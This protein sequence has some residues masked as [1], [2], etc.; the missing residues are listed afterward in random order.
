M[1]RTRLPMIL[2]SAS[3]FAA[4]PA[5]SPEGAD[6]RVVAADEVNS[7]ASVFLNDVSVLFPMPKGSEADLLLG[8]NS[9]GG[10]GEL[11]PQAAF[12]EIPPLVVGDGATRDDLRVVG[13]RIDPCFP[14]LG[15]EDPA[16]CLNQIRLVLQ[17]VLTNGPDTP[18]A[19]QD[20]SVHAFYTMSR[21]EFVAMVHEIVAAKHGATDSTRTPLGP[22]PL[23]VEQ[24]LSGPFA[25]KLKEIVLARAGKESLTRVTFMTREPAR[26]SMW[27]FGGFDVRDGVLTKLKIASLEDTT[28]QT[29]SMLLDN[30]TAIPAPQHE[31]DLSLLFRASEASNA[32]TEAL[33]KAYTAALKIQNPA[34]HSPDTIDCV[35]CHTATAAS[36]WSEKNK[37]FTS[38]G[39]PDAFTTSWNV[40][41]TNAP[42]VERRDNLHAFGYLGA[43]PSVNQR[44]ANESAL[45]ADYVNTKILGSR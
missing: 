42:A 7:G 36:I 34:R 6:D 24:G 29:F 10:K 43:D 11:L 33:T 27:K 37:G 21:E 8:A 35:S 26:L 30:G 41:L 15:V 2:V 3:L 17:P 13:L 39:N 44:V 25:T 45:V 20:A 9:A 19:A 22:N 12:D 4:V 31:D 5:C 40:A 38:E 23:I 32:S 28:E 1:D 18:L 14:G 16:G